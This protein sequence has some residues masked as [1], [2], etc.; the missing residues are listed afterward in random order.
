VSESRRAGA[1]FLCSKLR[2]RFFKIKGCFKSHVSIDQSMIVL[3]WFY[4]IFIGAATRPT[5]YGSF[6]RE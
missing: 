5:H 4:D 6:I 1:L 3:N 2:D